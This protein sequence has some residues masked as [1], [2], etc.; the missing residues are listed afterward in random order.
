[1][2]DP[3]LS[4]R[5]LEQDEFLRGH[6]NLADGGP[7]GI[8]INNNANVLVTTCQSR[9]LKF[10]DLDAILNE[11]SL[12]RV[13]NVGDPN[14]LTIARLYRQVR[15][16]TYELYRATATDPP[17]RGLRWVS[18]RVYEA[19]QKIGMKQL[20]VPSGHLA[21]GKS[22]L[23]RA[24]LAAE[25]RARTLLFRKRGFKSISYPLCQGGSHSAT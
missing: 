15:W 12:E 1:V 24:C 4:F 13:A 16:V 2:R 6:Y 25:H 22:A 20:R 21:P 5:V 3:L 10:Y 9:P 23:T 14:S 18:W 17:K 8:D 7:K 19:W 11:L